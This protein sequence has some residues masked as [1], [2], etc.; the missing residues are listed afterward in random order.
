M[1]RLAPKFLHF[2]SAK[3]VL[4]QKIN[5]PIFLGNKKR[6]INGAREPKKNRTPQYKYQ[7]S[8]F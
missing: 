3:V 5:A 8:H 4:F 7:K 2:S 6:S 1:A